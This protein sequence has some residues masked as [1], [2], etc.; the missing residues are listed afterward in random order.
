ML[1]C[2]SYRYNS[3]APFERTAPSVL[4]IGIISDHIPRNRKALRTVHGTCQTACCFPVSK[5]VK[6]KT[7][8]LI[9]D[10]TCVTRV[11][12]E[13]LYV[14]PPPPPSPAD[15]GRLQTYAITAIQDIFT[16]PD[17]DIPNPDPS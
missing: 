11:N 10:I 15:T 6:A 2:R 5:I 14:L 17:P 1:Y 9:V 12:Q 7:E 3:H 13:L 8:K 4:V 16:D